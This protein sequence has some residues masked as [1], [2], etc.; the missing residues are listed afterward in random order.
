MARPGP[1]ERNR[2]A[3]S[4]RELRRFHHLIKFG[5][6]FRYTPLVFM[7]DQRDRLDD[8]GRR[9]SH[10]EHEASYDGC[11]LRRLFDGLQ[12]LRSA[13][14]RGE[15]EAYPVAHAWCRIP[16]A[17]MAQVMTSSFT[18]LACN[19]CFYDMYIGLQ[20][21]HLRTLLVSLTGISKFCTHSP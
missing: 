7:L 12:V 19:E 18:V 8:A 21:S 2:A 3:R 5:L 6:G 4:F 9:R 11:R 17:G 16:T 1:P 15:R 10:R 20:S 14:G 13:D